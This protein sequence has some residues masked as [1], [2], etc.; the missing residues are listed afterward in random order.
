MVLPFVFIGK[1]MKKIGIVLSV[2]AIVA[3]MCI[4]FKAISQSS[5]WDGN[6]DIKLRL[7]IEKEINSY[8]ERRED[9]AKENIVEIDMSKSR[10]FLLEHRGFR[11]AKPQKLEYYSRIT[12]TMRSCH[13]LLPVNYNKDIEYPLLI[14]LHGYEGDS[15]S[16]INK[17]AHI[18]IQNLQYFQGI[19]PFI[20]V[21]ADSNLNEKNSVKNISYDEAVEIYDK[22]EEDIIGD[23]LPIVRKKYRISD[24]REELG[25][26]GLSLGGRNAL[27][28]GLKHREVF[29]YIGAFSPAN[30]QFEDEKNGIPPI[31]TENIDET[32][33]ENLPVYIEISTGRQDDDTGKLTDE[34]VRGFN[35]NH[36]PNI[37]YKMDGGHESKVWQN[38]LYNFVKN[39]YK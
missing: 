34:I 33:Y 16:W 11:Y 19:S 17:R 12:K 13:I 18:L 8:G 22:S 37:Y 1:K 10:Y 32:E 27:Y 39:L 20:A 25:V 15:T 7:S 26:C 21:F 2:L 3:S 28:I 31:M 5:F 14:L 30:F 23:L 6:R 38:A 36:I 35:R 4:L 24:K 9:T 29:K